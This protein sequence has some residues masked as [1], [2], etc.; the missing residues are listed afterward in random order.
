ME[1][2][3]K[4][5]KNENPIG[6]DIDNTLLTWTNPTVP[7]PG[8][9]AI[10]F[11][12]ET[13]YLTPHTYHVQLLKMY[14]ERGC[15]LIFWSANG[16]RHAE[17]AVKAL[18]LEYLADGKKGHIQTKLSKHMDDNP[19]AASILGPRVFEEDFTKPVPQ[20]ADAI[21]IG[22]KGDFVKVQGKVV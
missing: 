2:K 9:L 6:V 14:E 4:V 13:V 11:A 19:N 18:G 22:V 7:G 10:E 16:W 5:I 12:G 8:K 15:Y 3:V 21:V 1:L 17:R 20:L